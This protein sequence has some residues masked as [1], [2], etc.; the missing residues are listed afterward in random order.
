LEKY[1]GKKER[2]VRLREGKGEERKK[3]TTKGRKGRGK[4]L[5]E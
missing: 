3:G 2:K 5:S 4:H 1:D